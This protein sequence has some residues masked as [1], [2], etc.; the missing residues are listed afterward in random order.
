MLAP[1]RCPFDYNRPVP[2]SYPLRI[3]GEVKFYKS[4]LS[5][6]YIREYIGVL[7]D[8][9][10]NYFFDSENTNDIYPGKMEIG[11]Y[12]LATGFQDEAEKLAYCTQN[13]NYF[14]FK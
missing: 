12:F 11:V 9:Q 2:F 3:L 7:K 1:N 8:I 13:K 4:R 6:K 5:K 10:E 14:V